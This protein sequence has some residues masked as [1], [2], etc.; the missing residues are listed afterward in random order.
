MLFVTLRLLVGLL[1]RFCCAPGICAV[2]VFLPSGARILV[3]VALMAGIHVVAGGPAHCSM[4]RAVTIKE[5]SKVSGTANFPGKFLRL[6]A[7]RT[8]NLFSA[9][10]VLTVP[11]RGLWLLA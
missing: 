6:I 8:D 3:D 1:L 7:T 9:L 10:A 4:R 5:L 2:V 11:E